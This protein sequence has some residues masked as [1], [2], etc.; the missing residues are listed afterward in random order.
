M[1][2][3][4]VSYE[5]HAKDMKSDERNKDSVIS[6]MYVEG[7]FTF[8]KN[9]PWE[10]PHI[11][12]SLIYIM[13]KLLSVPEASGSHTKNQSAILGK[14][15]LGIP[16]VWQ[17][18]VVASPCL[19]GTIFSLLGKFSAGFILSS[20]DHVTSALE[21]IQ[22]KGEVGIGTCSFSTIQALEQFIP[23]L[24][25]QIHRRTQKIFYSSVQQNKSQENNSG[26]KSQVLGNK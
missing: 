7:K 21:L 12:R 8:Q 20:P 25:P 26:S 17:R 23:V 22:S 2:F 15:Q 19:W 18:H 9:R 10:M 4:P 16:L 14:L 13:Q 3:G 6:A 1:S 11:T 5:H 24:K